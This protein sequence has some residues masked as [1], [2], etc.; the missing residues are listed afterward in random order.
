MIRTIGHSTY[1]VE[2]FIELLR[3]NSIDTIVDVRSVPY[4]KYASQYNREVL[5][6]CLKYENIRYIYMGDILGARYK[7]PKLLF[8]SGKVDFKKVQKSKLFL[9]GIARLQ[10]GIAKGYN[11][12]LMCSERETFDCHRFV[13]ISGFLAKIGTAV[14]HIY[15][16]K[17]VSQ[18]QM[19]R[20]LL[21]KYH[22][23]LHKRDLF[24]HS[25][26]Q[27]LQLQLAYEL[28]N[29]DIAYN[30]TSKNDSIQTV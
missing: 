21:I 26:T 2:Y 30:P 10:D 12:S 28:R 4:S 22:K 23:K 3:K 7:D 8:D 27:A 25:I 29:K 14:E 19:E 17:V 16:D 20:Q 11:I 1:D 15:P 13:L 9:E 6:Q 18:A 5:K 24:C